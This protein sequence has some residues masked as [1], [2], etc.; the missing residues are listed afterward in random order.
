MPPPPTP[1]I[2]ASCRKPFY[3]PGIMLGSIRVCPKCWEEINPR[4]RIKLIAL[5]GVPELVKEVTAIVKQARKE[6]EEGDWGR[7]LGRG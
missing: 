6:S 5:S 1:E 7:L 2:C 4:D 3:A